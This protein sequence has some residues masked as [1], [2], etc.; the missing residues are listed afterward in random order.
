[1]NVSVIATVRNEEGA[2]GALLTSLLKQTRR[3]DDVVICDGGSTD[4][5]LAVLQS[6]AASRLPL[7]VVSAPGSNISEGRNCAINAALGQIVAVTDAGVILEAD[8]LAHL[9]PPL[10]AGEADVVGGFFRPAAQTLFEAAMGATV[11]PALADIVPAQFLPSSRSVAFTRAAWEKVGGYPQWLDYCEDLVFD[12]A[13]KQAGCRF[14]FVPQASV[15]F[16]PR[17]SLRA[18]FRQYYRY[19]RGDGKADL[20]RKRHLMRYVTY[21][22]APLAILLGL[23]YNIVWLGLALAMLAYCWRPWQRLWPEVAGAP[24]ADRLRALALVP[25]IRFVGD[26]AKMMGYPAGLWWRWQRQRDTGE[27][28]WTQRATGQTGGASQHT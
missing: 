11:L 12:L 1:M 10:L 5:T 19:A 24:R 22:A 23:R 20:W 18:F 3:P 27:P 21:V 7:R 15:A 4:G 13:L 26:L 9:L 14:V 16:R 8:W 28:P 17:S 25:V 2:V 6:F